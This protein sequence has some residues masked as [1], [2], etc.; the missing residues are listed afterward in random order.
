MHTFSRRFLCLSL[1]PLPINI[2]H[3]LPI[4][5]PFSSS[6]F[7]VPTAPGLLFATNNSSN[8]SKLPHLCSRHIIPYCVLRHHLFSINLRKDTCTLAQLQ[9]L[10]LPRL[11]LPTLLS[12]HIFAL[13]HIILYC[14]LRL[15]L[16]SINLRK[17]SCTSAKRSAG[18]EDLLDTRSLSDRLYQKSPN[19]SSS[20]EEQTSSSTPGPSSSYKS[21]IW[22]LQ[23]GQPNSAPKRIR[24]PQYPN[25]EPIPGTYIYRSS[26]QQCL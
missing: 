6:T 23:N 25:H 15:H 10:P 12:F 20:D 22:A 8:S 4:R 2:P 3:F 21:S 1:C 11:T 19:Q 26:D 7:F 13:R 16:F 17:D 18:S 9:S 5:L 14:I 24:L